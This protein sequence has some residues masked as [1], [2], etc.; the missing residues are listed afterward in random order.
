MNS[1]PHDAQNA[2]APLEVSCA[3]QEIAILAVAS[4]GCERAA[5]WSRRALA[6]Q[7]WLAA[8]GFE[9]EA[10]DH[11][12]PRLVLDVLPA[13][14]VLARFYAGSGRVIARAKAAARDSFLPDPRANDF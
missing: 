1:L 14:P 7:G 9:Q 6:H 4:L 10:V 13:D 12:G 5:Y 11:A 2:D 3:E 8:G